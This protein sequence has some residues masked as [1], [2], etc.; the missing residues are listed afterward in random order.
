MEVQWRTKLTKFGAQSTNG[1]GFVIVTDIR[2]SRV[3]RSFCFSGESKHR[4]NLIILA[5]TVVFRREVLTS[6]VIAEDI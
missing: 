4:S 1:L 5:G 3:T 6:S 2:L